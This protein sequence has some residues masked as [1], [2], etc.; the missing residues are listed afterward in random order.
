MAITN[1][2]NSAA[3]TPVSNTG[4]LTVVVVDDN[5]QP[6]QGAQVSITPSD[7]S[8]TTNSAG[9]I[10]F[11]LGTAS[12]YSITAS[13]K[14]NT[15]TVPYYVTENGATRLLVN[16]VYVKTVEKQLDPQPFINSNLITGIGIGLGI[17]V[18]IVIVWKF[19]IR[20]QR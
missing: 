3:S 11:K 4:V 6:T 15:V 9:E 5:G 20:R 18:V 16:P 1:V 2:K 14:S 10:Q 19:L 7:A 12:K 8:G 13:Y 17:I